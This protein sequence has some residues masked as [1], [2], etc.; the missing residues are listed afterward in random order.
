MTNRWKCAFLTGALVLGAVSAAEAQALPGD[1]AA[2]LSPN[3][4]VS[5]SMD[6][7]SSALSLTSGNASI[8]LVSPRCVASNRPRGCIAQI[9]QFQFFLA[10]FE[11]DT[12]VGH[13]VVT[14]PSVSLV[15]PTAVKDT[16][17]GFVVPAGTM[18]GFN[19]TV[20]AILKNE[21]T[22]PLSAPAVFTLSTAT[23]DLA[24]DGSFP[25]QI[26][27]ALGDVVTGTVTLMATAQ[28][29]F[30]NTPPTP[31]A[32]PDQTVSCGQQINLDGSG[33]TD[34]ENNITTYIWSANGTVIATGAVAHVT[35]P[36]G[37]TTVQLNVQDAFGAS[38]VDALT[39]TEHDAAP[40]FSFVPP[41]FQAP[42]CGVPNIGQAK[43]TATC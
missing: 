7:A 35:L 39:V 1:I 14:D 29:P 26:S 33:S 5:L 31:N 24:I 2:N 17:T 41:A 38:A 10:P 23:Q 22:V 32:G 20:S 13:F 40:V 42:T 8:A 30:L 4:L 3:S 9:Q 37:V 11:M 28:K 18:M 12:T 16:G 27:N 36:P 19:A 6:G 34:L 15:N 25:F 21:H 43:A